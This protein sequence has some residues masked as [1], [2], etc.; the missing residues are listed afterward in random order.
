MFFQAKKEEI[1]FVLLSIFR[2]FAGK[3][4]K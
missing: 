2:N 3:S 4:T 1:S